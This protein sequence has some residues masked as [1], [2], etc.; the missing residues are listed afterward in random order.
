MSVSDPY[1]AL[2]NSIQKGPS[3]TADPDAST[4]SNDILA[5][6]VESPQ[7]LPVERL[8]QEKGIAVVE[9]Y[10]GLTSLLEVGLAKVSGDPGEELVELTDRGSAAA[11]HGDV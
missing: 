9:F 3:A 6:L 8:R 5:S 10:R 7:P 4:T 11:R 2:L 1:S